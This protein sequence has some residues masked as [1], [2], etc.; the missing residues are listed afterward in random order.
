MAGHSQFKNIMH[1]KGAQD[2][3]RAK[4]FAKLIRELTVASKEG[5]EDP[6]GNPRLRTAIAAAK[7]S[8]LPRDTMDRAVKRGLGNTD[9]VS[10][11]EV[12]YE[13]YAPGGVAFIVD[14]LTDNRNRTASI[15]R[16]TFTKF[17][18]SLGETNSVAFQ[19]SRIGM[20]RYPL[21]IGCSENILEIAIEV[22]ADEVVET[23][24]EYE[25]V[26]SPKEFYE[27]RTALESKF[28]ESTNCELTWKPITTVMLNEDHAN[29]IFKLINALDECDDVQNIVSNFEVSDSILQKLSI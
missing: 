23:D 8:N 22:G 20:I 5:G 1:R 12:R 17:G 3:K 6:D 11:E 7:A 25:F 15:V 27:V 2:A 21:S 18:G 16:S 9:Q 24:V 29:N 19:F 10:F 28:S 26:S 14:A 13:G 4:I